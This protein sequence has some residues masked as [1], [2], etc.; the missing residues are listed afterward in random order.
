MRI[1]YYVTAVTLIFAFTAGCSHYG[2]LG[3]DYGMS[4]SMAKQGQILNPGASKNPEPVTGLNGN[5]AGANEEKYIQSFSKG[6]GGQA[7]KGFVVPMIPAGTAGM[8]QDVY[9]K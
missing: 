3:K 1:K 7:S 2:T 6:S 4:Y 9:G 8:G 5:A